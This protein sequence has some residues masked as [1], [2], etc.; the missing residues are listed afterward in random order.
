MS[1]SF[2]P[3][4]IKYL[5][6]STIFLLAMVFMVNSS[7]LYA[8]DYSD[9]K[10]LQKKCK[11]ESKQLEIAVKNFGSKTNLKN[12]KKGVK[13]IKMGNIKLMQSKYIEAIKNYKE[14]LKLQYLLYKSLAAIYIK[15]TQQIID[16]VAV[17]LIDYTDND[18][19][20]KYLKLASE[21]LDNAKKSKIRT[22]YKQVIEGCRMAKRYALGAYKLAEKDIP[23]KY[24]KDSNDINKKIN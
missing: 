16:D 8:S 7:I 10:D 22:H 2:K 4:N 1:N 13:L 14:Y 6:L 18:D 3:T 23:E 11:D 20:A 17:D 19:V 9:A 24:K 15:H 5:S 12:F 21:N